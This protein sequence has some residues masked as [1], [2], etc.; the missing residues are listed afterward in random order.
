M[1]GRWSEAAATVAAIAIAALHFCALLPYRVPAFA[2]S[3]ENAYLVAAKALVEEGRLPV[4]PT[5]PLEFV[6]TMWVEN[7]R[8]EYYPKYPPGHSLL[9]AA[10]RWLAGPAAVY[11]VNPLAS[12]AL[13]VLFFLFLRAFFRHA[14][15]GANEPLAL[16]PDALAVMGTALL[17]ANPSFLV[18]A[19]SSLSHSTAVLVE[20]AGLLLGAFWLLKG[21]TGAA[22]GAGL[23]LGAAGAVRYTDV[24]FLLPVAAVAARRRWAGGRFP[25]GTLRF[26]LGAA[27]PLAALAGYHWVAFDGPLRTGYALTG[28][29]AGF[30]LRLF[31]HNGPVLFAALLAGGLGL[32]LP[33]ALLEAVALWRRD[34]E[35]VL[36]FVL[37][38]VPITLLY[39]S[40]YWASESTPF[41]L[42]RFVLGIYLA[43][44]ALGLLHLA[45]LPFAAG[46]RLV[47]LGAVAAGTLFLSLPLARLGLRGIAERNRG[48]L[49]VAR[50]VGE[51]LPEGSALIADDSVLRYLD[52]LDKWKLYNK[53][54]F[55]AAG[56]ERLHQ[57]AADEGA[58]FLQPE[59][60]REILAAL[61]ADVSP[62][63][64]AAFL[65]EFAA[66]RLAGGGRLGILSS[67]AEEEDLRSA[68]GPGF[69]LTPRGRVARAPGPRPPSGAPQ[70]APQ[71]A[72]LVLY[73]VIEAA[74]R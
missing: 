74:G 54:F 55:E 52:Y 69:A 67:E 17:A 34:R 25:A 50:L 57:R 37:W 33:L 27:V 20:T 59:R 8:G 58:R 47:A 4:Q 43:L 14:A 61:P 13:V 73:E 49:E 31:V 53:D 64:L 19:V 7:G 35:A 18:F 70:G 66:R 32:F 6:G 1:S 42:V 28:E 24:V 3:D 16:S 21:A 23:L 65:R 22:L 48:S 68:L 30:G 51:A 26:V 39:A 41:S 38:V 62:G 44:V 45:S 15:R 71:E 40:Y 72:E 11:W 5:E 46:S 36:F 2:L 29:Q 10:A 9:L 60:A 56:V 12:T 63:A